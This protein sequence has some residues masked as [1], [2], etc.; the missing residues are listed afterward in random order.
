MP[1]KHIIPAASLGVYTDVSHSHAVVA[2]LSTVCVAVCR[3]V[4]KCR[5]SFWR[6]VHGR[7]ED[8]DLL[9]ISYNGT[10]RPFAKYCGSK[11]PPVTM[12]TDHEAE[13]LF[14]SRRSSSPST[15][16][17]WHSESFGFRAEF[18]F[19]SGKK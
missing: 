15:S 10:P 6:C 4:M 19:I 5:S 2:I 9:V 13:V 18:A 1:P 17:S 12:S 16:S 3:S 8:V 14:F 11:V 7:C